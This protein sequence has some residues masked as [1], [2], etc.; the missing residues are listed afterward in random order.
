MAKFRMVRTDFW[1]NPI[2]SDEM[3]P[4]DKYFLPISAYK[5]ANYSNWNLQKYQKANGF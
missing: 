1:K 4:E 3:T 5:S 2:V